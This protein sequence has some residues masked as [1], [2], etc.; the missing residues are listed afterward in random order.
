MT[1]K[2]KE[3]SNDIESIQKFTVKKGDTLWGIAKKH[4][5]P[6]EDIRSLI[7]KIRKINNLKSVEIRPGQVIE[8]PVS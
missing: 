2:L 7:Y 6:G 1:F 5:A 4:S 3:Q 8:I